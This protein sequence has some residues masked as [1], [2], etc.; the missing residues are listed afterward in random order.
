M[1]IPPSSSRFAYLKDYISQREI[2]LSLPSRWA[3]GTSGEDNH[4][5][6]RY[7]I[8]SWSQWAGQKIRR[9]TADV[10]TID[11]VH[12]FPGWATRHLHGPD[13]PEG[14]LAPPPSS[15]SNSPLTGTFDVV[16]HVSGF[17]TSR[18]TP[19]FLTRSQRAFL[20]LAR[21]TDSHCSGVGA[22]YLVDPHN[23]F[24]VHTQTPAHIAS[25]R[26]RTTRFPQMAAPSAPPRRNSR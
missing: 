26:Y 7:A 12:L 24:C 6:A 4:T 8:Q 19:E 13:E 18:R 5:Q 15:C 10:A 20:K 1:A 9:S 25:T 11:E 21:S 3:T 2:K 23:R 14:K 22:L 17:A 16:L